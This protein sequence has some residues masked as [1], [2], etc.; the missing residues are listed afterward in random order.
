MLNNSIIPFVSRFA[1]PDQLS[2]LL[3]CCSRLAVHKSIYQKG[4]HTANNTFKNF[5]QSH[6]IAITSLTLYFL[7]FFFC[8]LTVLF[9]AT[10]LETKETGY[11]KDMHP[12]PPPPYNPEYTLSPSLAPPAFNPEFSS[13]NSIWPTLLAPARIVVDDNGDDIKDNDSS[14]MYPP[15]ALAIP[16]YGNGFPDP[17]TI[18]THVDQVHVDKQPTPPPASA[19][20]TRTQEWSKT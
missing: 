20:E 11:A 8:K 3:V 16:V 12:N 19:S 10:M 18:P 13:K 17:A 2:N 7:T 4:N 6:I 14:A 5:V 15:F 1:S 9:L